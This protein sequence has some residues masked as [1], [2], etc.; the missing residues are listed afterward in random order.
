MKLKR[1]LSVAIGA[2][3]TVAA[4]RRIIRSGRRISFQGM[5]I[6]I[7]GGSRGLGLVMARRFAEENAKLALL[8]RDERELERAREDLERYGVEVLTIPCDV[9]EEDDVKSAFDR[10]LARFG[11]VDVLVNNAGIM[12]VGPIEHMSIDDFERSMDVHMW[13]P[14][15]T[16]LAA[17]PRMREQGGGRIVNIASIGG[18]IGVPH[19]TP[20]S[21]S[22]FALVGLSEAMRAELKKDNIYVTTVCPFMLRTGSPLNAD[23][24]GHHEEEFTWFT[25]SGS[26]PLLSMNAERAAHRIIEACRYGDAEPGIG[27]QARTLII[28]N[29]LFPELIADLLAGANRL[30]PGRAREG[31]AAQT[32]WESQSRWAPSLLTRLTDRAA[33]KNNEIPKKNGVH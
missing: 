15:R 32:G 8:A 18:K 5:T 27:F 11:S 24:K 21:A 31:D 28:M 7:T 20:Y 30:L 3:A 23:F 22:K 1:L 29:A 6:V 26:L 10:I 17:V 25:I 9:R 33:A 19:L 12:Q 14:L 13:G 2:A 16:M 4:V